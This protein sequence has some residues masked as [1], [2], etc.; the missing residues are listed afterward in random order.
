[1]QTEIK[2]VI[3]NL[4]SIIVTDL[5]EERSDILRFISDLDKRF[6]ECIKTIRAIF[7]KVYQERFNAEFIW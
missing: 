7:E 5:P 6:P 1:M 4:T 2:D 3:E